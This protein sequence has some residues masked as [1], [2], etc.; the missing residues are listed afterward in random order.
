MSKSDTF[1]KETSW[2]NSIFLTR[3]KITDQL[4]DRLHSSQMPAL[5][6]LGLMGQED[7]PLALF[8]V[9]IDLLF[10]QI[11]LCFLF[12]LNSVASDSGTTIFR[13]L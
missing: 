12:N 8:Y 13:L 3:S 4:V 1:N 7:R 6:L 9:S 11:F 10:M 2:P 5:G